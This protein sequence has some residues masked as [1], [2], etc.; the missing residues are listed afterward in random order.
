VNLSLVFKPFINLS[1]RG[2]EVDQASSKGTVE[3]EVDAGARRPAVRYADKKTVGPLG[4]IESKSLEQFY[5]ASIKST[6]PRQKNI[7]KTA[8][9]RKRRKDKS[10]NWNGQ[11]RVPDGRG[12]EV[13]KPT[14]DIMQ[15]CAAHCF[16]MHPAIRD[17]LHGEG[18]N[19][20]KV[21]TQLQPDF[22]PERRIFF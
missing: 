11:P 22:Q 19:M 21:G 9:G 6:V 3:K 15:H 14:G 4:M 1:F 20:W 7:L 16:T 10:S 17:C 2:R 13:R 18:Q 8:V 5:H 12:A